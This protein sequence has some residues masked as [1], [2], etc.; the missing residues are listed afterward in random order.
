MQTAAA[1]TDA[2]NKKHF[3]SEVL[4]SYLTA[5]RM[6]IHADMRATLDSLG[7]KEE[8]S[9]SYKFNRTPAYACV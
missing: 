5:H 6:I 2:E 1:P 9:N 4:K 8:R 7:K 3:I